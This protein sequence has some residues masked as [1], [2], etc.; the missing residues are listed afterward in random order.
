[1]VKRRQSRS[2]DVRNKDFREFLKA[3]RDR[4]V[5]K[6]KELYDKGF[7]VPNKVFLNQL[8]K[9]LNTIIDPNPDLSKGIP[10]IFFNAYQYLDPENINVRENGHTLLDAVVQM[11]TDAI[12]IEPI[13]MKKNNL[14]FY[15]LFFVE[16]LIKMGAQM[17]MDIPIPQTVPLSEQLGKIIT[18]LAEVV[19][20]PSAP[21][22]PYS[23]E[24]ED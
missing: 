14:I 21:D 18:L 5:I 2:I 1:M 23:S 22:S 13:D 3:F 6:L 15:Y 10:T 9:E 7:R 16:Y 4:N 17:T 19:P 24:D 11:F 8:E 12:D 20:S